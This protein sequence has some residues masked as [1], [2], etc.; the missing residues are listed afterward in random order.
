MSRSIGVFCKSHW[1][2]RLLALSVILLAIICNAGQVSAQKERPV[3]P[4]A[5]ASTTVYSLNNTSAYNAA[6]NKESVGEGTSELIPVKVLSNPTRTS[7]RVF[8]RGSKEEEVTFSILDRQG[9]TIDKRQ[10]SAQAELR[11]GYWYHPGTYFLDVMKDG[12]HQRIRLV[13]LA[14]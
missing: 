5:A 14:D 6:L 9:R 11:F 13:K 4:D 10:V 2:K 3:K 8:L 12:K 1:S 7:F